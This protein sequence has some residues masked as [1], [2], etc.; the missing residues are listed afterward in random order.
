M[1]IYLDLIIIENLIMNLIIVILTAKI[2]KYKIK[3]V[4]II[5]ACLIETAYMAILVI[6]NKQIKIKERII[7]AIILNTIAFYPQKHKEMFKTCCVFLMITCTLGGT[8]LALSTMLMI[9]KMKISITA[10]ILGTILIYEVMRNNKRNINKK[11]LYIN[12]E[13]I[14]KNKSIKFKAFI[15]TGNTLKSIS[16]KEVIIIK[17]NKFE[18][19]GG[20]EIIIPF[21]S[22]GND[23]GYLIGYVPDQV[24]AY[25]RGEKIKIDAVLAICDGKILG[26]YDALASSSL[27]YI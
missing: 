9:N 21:K 27:L 17:K 8:A 4:R 22:V 23:N 24:W 12:I 19:P 26:K 6:Q 16:K 14:I 3:L 18:I 15:D 2:R 5:L 1:I 11:D 10:G 13:A 25:K 7:S 20:G